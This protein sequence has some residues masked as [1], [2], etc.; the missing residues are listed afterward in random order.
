M[1]IEAKSLELFSV[2]LD[3]GRGHKA[4]SLSPVNE[5]D[6]LGISR[7]LRYVE[8]HLAEPLA[9]RSLAQQASMSRSKFTS[10]FKNHTG[11]SA[12]PFPQNS[13]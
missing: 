3:W 5:Q 9:L 1:R 4:G 6:R 10:V 8:E 11:L 7:A 2:I 13:L 12:F